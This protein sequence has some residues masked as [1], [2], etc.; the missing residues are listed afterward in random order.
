MHVKL[1]FQELKQLTIV[2]DQLCPRNVRNPILEQLI[3]AKPVT[4]NHA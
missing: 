3:Y 1:V 2:N 4:K